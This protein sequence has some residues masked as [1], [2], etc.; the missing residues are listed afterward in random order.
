MVHLF[1]VILNFRSSAANKIFPYKKQLENVSR[2]FRNYEQRLRVSYTTFVRA[3]EGNALHSR[4]VTN[5]NDM[6]D[7]FMDDCCPFK[8]VNIGTPE[9]IV[10]QE[11]L[12]LPV[13]T[14]RTLGLSMIISP[15][16]QLGK[17]LC[18]DQVV[19][20]CWVASFLNSP[21]RFNEALTRLLDSNSV[22][23][24]H[25]YYTWMDSTFDLFDTWQGGTAPRYSSCGNQL[26]DI[27]GMD[28]DNTDSR[29]RLDKV[30]VILF[31]WIDFI[32]FYLG[33]VM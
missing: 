20:L 19:E 6:R 24:K 28:K 10:N 30:L 1:Q 13:G 8:T 12:S 26:L 11:L 33:S 22:I 16:Y 3:Y 23:D 18:V 21:V 31:E 9:K 15:I 7:F 29:D 14:S 25:P 5:P 4:F 27:F 32:N 2:H 17:M